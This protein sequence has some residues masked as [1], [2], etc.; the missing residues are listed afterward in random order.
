M[1]KNFR[2]QYVAEFKFRNAWDG[3]WVNTFVSIE[4]GKRYYSTKKEAE[5]ALRKVIARFNNRT[6][7]EEVDFVGDIG[8]S[9]YVDQETINNLTVV[10]T[11]I[12]VREV[13]EWEEC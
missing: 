8:I 10:K 1:K 13:T 7:G 3:K 9:T 11:R 12:R 2:K 4:N 6:P 5:D